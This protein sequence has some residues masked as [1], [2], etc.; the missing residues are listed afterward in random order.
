M[1]S[2]LGRDEAD[3]VQGVLGLR[4]A[5]VVVAVAVAAKSS[6]AAAASLGQAEYS[7]AP[8]GTSR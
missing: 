8:T 2:G 1:I 7:A 3:K 4:G 6:Q 5:A